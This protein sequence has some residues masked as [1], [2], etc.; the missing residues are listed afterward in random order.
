VFFL[1]GNAYERSDHP[2]EAATA[3]DE[4]VKRYPQ[5]RYANQAKARLASLQ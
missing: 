1:L 5:S 3:F 4:L 2:Q